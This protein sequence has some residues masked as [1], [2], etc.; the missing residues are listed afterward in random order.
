MSYA[1]VIKTSK[2]I[3][4]ILE[5]HGAT[6]RG[7]HEKLSSIESKLDNSLVKNIR[8][9]ATVRNKLIHEDDI[10]FTPDLLN[11]FQKVADDIFEALKL[12]FNES[13]NS[14]NS[15]NNTD[16]FFDK[17]LNALDFAKKHPLKTIGLF[18]FSVASLIF[19]DP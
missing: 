17:F 2:R 10:E 9:I 18:V 13:S 4:S 7:L 19:N 16:D 11:D 1:L 3:E 8:F 14:S 6:G 5:T 15:S 12:T